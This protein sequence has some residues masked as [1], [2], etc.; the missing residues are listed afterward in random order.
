MADKK[1][2]LWRICVDLD[3][4]REEAEYLESINIEADDEDEAL[5]KADKI[6]KDGMFG[7]PYY[8]VSEYPDYGDENED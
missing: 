7:G 8:N 5:E 3:A 6:V 1:K 4:S 2:Q